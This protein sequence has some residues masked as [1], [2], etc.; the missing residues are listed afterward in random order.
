MLI[1]DKVDF[2]A[3]KIT[4]DKEAHYMMIKRSIHREAVLNVGIKQENSRIQEAIT[5]RTESR[6][7]QIHSYSWD[8]ST[9]PVFITDKTARQKITKNSK[10]QHLNQWI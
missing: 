7:T 6:N 4:G 1:L 9:N 3:N 8:I 5:D 2:R 10:E